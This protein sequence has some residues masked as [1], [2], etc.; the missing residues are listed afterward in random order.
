MKFNSKVKTES[1][2]SVHTFTFAS[3]CRPM[4]RLR[5]PGL[6]TAVHIPQATLEINQKRGTGDFVNLVLTS[7]RGSMTH[8]S[9]ELVA[10]AL[11]ALSS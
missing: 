4:Q 3:F 5:K 8:A 2:S 6:V 11:V 1:S 9:I 10:V 7:V